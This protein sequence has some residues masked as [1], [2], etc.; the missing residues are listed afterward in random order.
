M[1]RP[2][3]WRDR[4]TWFLLAC[5]TGLFLISTLPRPQNRGVVKIFREI[6]AGAGA[7]TGLALALIAFAAIFSPFQRWSQGLENAQD[8]DSTI[9]RFARILIHPLFAALALLIAFA[10]LTFPHDF[11]R[12]I[13]S[14]QNADSD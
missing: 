7:A 1:S 5:G 2:P 11:A 14:L 4:W 6:A 10:V 13:A 9:E 12:G 3:W 8:A